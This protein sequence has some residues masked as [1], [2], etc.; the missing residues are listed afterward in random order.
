M[1]HLVRLD[2]FIEHP[3]SGTVKVK[4]LKVK[5]FKGHIHWIVKFDLGNIYL[6]KEK[7]C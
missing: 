2:A 3:S 4:Y 5:Y 6:R 1:S 7:L